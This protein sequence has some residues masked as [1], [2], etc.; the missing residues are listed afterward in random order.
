VN[1][2]GDAI[3]RYLMRHCNAILMGWFRRKPAPRNE[4][5]KHIGIHDFY[6]GH[7]SIASPPASWDA[8]SSSAR[9]RPTT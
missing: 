8:F 6:Y 7:P 4:F 1:P 9:R 5:H 3:G 2:A